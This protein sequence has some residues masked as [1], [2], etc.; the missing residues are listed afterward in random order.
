MLKNS[1]SK[2]NVV[3]A[4]AG[5]NGLISSILLAKH[6]YK[7]TILESSSHIGGQY[8]GVKCNQYL[9][10]SALYIPQLTGIKEIDDIFLSEKKIV[11][12]Y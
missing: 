12:R 2:K 6:G 3:I 5:I 4:G 10:D 8:R 7:V 11:V 1:K 9:F